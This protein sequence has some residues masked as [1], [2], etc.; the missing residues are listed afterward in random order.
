MLAMCF[1]SAILETM[2]DDDS[3]DKRR[4]PWGKPVHQGPWGHEGKRSGGGGGDG[5]SPMDLEDLLRAAREGLDSQGGGHPV[6]L[7][8][9]ILLGLLALWGAS[10]LYMV[11]PGENAVILRFGALSR[12]QTEQ[13][14]G[15]H[16]PWPIESRQILDV[17]QVRNLPIG[18]AFMLDGHK[19]SL[20]QESMILTSDRNLVQVLLTVQW[21]IKSAENYL[22][23]I[24]DPEDTLK[25]MA[26]SALREV[27]GQTRMTPLVNDQGAMS[28]TIQQIIQKN[29]DDYDAG[30]IVN[31]VQFNTI[32]VHPDAQE[33]FQDVQSAK[34]DAENAKNLAGAYLNDVVPRARGEAAQ[35]TQ[36]AEAYKEATVAQA[37]GGAERF[38]ALY[39][40]YLQGKEV[41]RTRLYLEM[42][43]SVLGRANTII[44][45]GEAGRGALPYLSLEKMEKSGGPAR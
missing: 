20:P 26:E 5:G 28:H 11:S 2:S 33:A 29:L 18:Y 22:F 43:E 13:G 42:M 32:E 25:K 3:N 37:Q 7:L 39:S 9:I 21:N 31:A 1:K 38:N 27:V 45:D 24:A 15:Y 8:L 6:R 41:T 36:A 30:I 40:A 10:G 44:L 34:Q 35:M 16:M 23:R 4:N 12:V 14:L 19:E 17:L